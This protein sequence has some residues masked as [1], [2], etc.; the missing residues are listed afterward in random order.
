MSRGNEEY[1]DGED[2]EV[3]EVGGMTSHFVAGNDGAITEKKTGEEKT[4]KERK[5]YWSQVQT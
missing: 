2:G 1:K 4:I 5:R 3:G